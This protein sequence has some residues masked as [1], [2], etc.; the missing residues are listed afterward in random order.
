[1]RVLH[2]TNSDKHGGAS[3]AAYRL[4]KALLKKGIDSKMLVLDKITDEKEIFSIT[5]NRK[6]ISDF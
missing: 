4:H 5:E 2:I 3:I 6:N 1:M